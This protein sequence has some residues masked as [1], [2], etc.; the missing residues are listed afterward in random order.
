MKAINQTSAVDALQK[1]WIRRIDVGLS[2]ALDY[3]KNLLL[4]PLFMVFLCISEL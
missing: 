2:I 1:R 4:T 3:P